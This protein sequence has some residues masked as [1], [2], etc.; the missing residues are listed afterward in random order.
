MIRRLML[1]ILV[2][3]AVSSGGL[4]PPGRANSPQIE[5]PAGDHPVGWADLVSVSLDVTNSPTGEKLEVKFTLAEA[6]TADNRRTMTGYNLNGT[7]G[8]CAL[9]VIFEALPNAAPDIGVT[10]GYATAHCGDP[11]DFVTGAYRFDD[12]SIIVSYPLLDLRGVP[13]GATMKDLRAHTAP[14]Q[15]FAHDE[16]LILAN[17]GDHATSDKTWVVGS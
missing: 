7:V 12:K 2:L 3:C 8:K 15:G 5:D 1:A 16:N 14:V 11:A 9:A 4:A 10:E 17:A 6:S 13:L